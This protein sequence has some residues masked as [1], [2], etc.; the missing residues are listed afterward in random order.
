MI[1]FRLV[2]YFFLIGSFCRLASS[3]VSIYLESK[4]NEN[5]LEVAAQAVRLSVF[6]QLD[7]VSNVKTYEGD[8]HLPDE[9]LN[10]DKVELLSVRRQTGLDGLI[11]VEIKNHQT[12]SDLLLL[13]LS[14]V[15][16]S[17]G[18]I[19]CNQ[20]FE[21]R[22][23]INLLAKIEDRVS[24]FLPVLIHYYDAKLSII[25][26]PSPA[27]IWLNDQKIG[28]TPSRSL[29]VPA[30]HPHQLEIKRKG[31]VT[32][33]R[34]IKIQS[35]QHLLVDID[36]TDQITDQ[37]LQKQRYLDSM[38]F[39]LGSQLHLHSRNRSI[40]KV[41]PATS[42]RYLSKFGTWQFGFDLSSTKW[43][44]KQNIDTVL[45]PSTG[46]SN[47]TFQMNRFVFLSQYNLIEWINQFDLY[48]GLQL[49]ITNCRFDYQTTPIIDRRLTEVGTSNPVAGVE[50]GSRIYFGHHLK[51]QL[52]TGAE[53]SGTVP[54]YQKQANYW[55]DSTYQ[56]QTISLNRL[57]FGLAGTYSLW[58][59]RKKQN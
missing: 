1:L 52:F 33:R 8:I 32:H 14:L 17:A 4:T 12:N 50:V 40:S 38:N 55:G 43:E 54:Y 16:F 42:F 36:L 21:D 10:M 45:G 27:E 39:S 11:K 24:K 2:F 20:N 58:P 15:D 56:K 26:E 34:V 3:Q 22:F 25:S 46:N 7:Q 51:M 9:I 31:Y 28:Q 59:K 37:L 23:G 41:L 47:F 30:N 48:L 19:V 5:E 6:N 18:Q 57:Y 29:T 13:T 49:G 44:G 53:F 35:G